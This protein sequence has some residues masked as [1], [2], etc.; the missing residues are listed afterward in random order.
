MYQFNHRVVANGTPLDARFDTVALAAKR[1]GYAPAMFGYTD[2]AIDPRLAA[3][4]DDPRLRTYYG[5]LPGFDAVRTSP[6]ITVRGSSWLAELGYDV[7]PGPTGLLETEPDRPAEHSI[8]AFLT[9]RAVAWIDEQNEPWFAHLSY[10]R[11]HPRTPPRGGGP[12]STTRPTSAGRSSRSS[13]APLPRRG[14]ADSGGERRRPTPTS[15]PVL[16]AQYFGMIG[17]V[18]HRSAA[19]R[20]AAQHAASGTTP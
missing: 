19:V 1:A 14:A 15:W 3:G 7:S 4:P 5:I 2:Q 20:R 18:D 17:H 6:T 13:A 10:L 16:R 12:T 11:P 9:D 8:G